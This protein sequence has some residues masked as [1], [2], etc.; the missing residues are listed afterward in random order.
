MSEEQKAKYKR[1]THQGLSPLKTSPMGGVKKA[2]EDAWLDWFEKG[3]KGY[4]SLAEQADLSPEELAEYNKKEIYTKPPKG[5]AALQPTKTKKIVESGESG[6]AANR[7]RVAA[8]AG[9]KA[10][11]RWGKKPV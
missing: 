2:V 1:Q 5:G 4:M 11:T 3:D 10:V 7:A 6:A 8:D 9:K